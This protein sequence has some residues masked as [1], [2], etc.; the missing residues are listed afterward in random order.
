MRVKQRGPPGNVI[1][2]T[3][4]RRGDVDAI[5]YRAVSAFRLRSRQLNRIHSTNRLRSNRRA[6]SASGAGRS[7]CVNRP[8]APRVRLLPAL[9]VPRSTEPTIVGGASSVRGTACVRLSR[10][11]KR[12]GRSARN[13]GIGGSITALRALPNHSCRRGLR[14]FFINIHLV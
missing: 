8:H 1:C 6:V 13:V 14:S 5:P 11:R 2:S 4:P 3:R 7:A 10:M 12:N 9:S